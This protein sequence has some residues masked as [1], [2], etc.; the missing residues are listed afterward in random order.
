MSKGPV[1]AIGCRR[2]RSQAGEPPGPDSFVRPPSLRKGLLE[3]AGLSFWKNGSRQHLFLA[4]SVF[5]LRPQA[6]PL[7]DVR[8]AG[9]GGAGRSVRNRSE[10]EKAIQDQRW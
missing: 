3:T 7:A 6:F 10:T 1:A 8:L 5:K 2:D 9:Y 4:F